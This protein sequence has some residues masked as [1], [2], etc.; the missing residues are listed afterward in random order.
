MEGEKMNTLTNTLPQHHREKMTAFFCVLIFVVFS[1]ADFN[2]NAAWAGQ[3]LEERTVSHDVTDFNPTMNSGQVNVTLNIETPT[4]ANETHLPATVIKTT[5]IP[6]NKETTAT[7]SLCG[8][9]ICDRDNGEKPATCPADCTDLCNDGICSAATEDCNNCPE[10]CGICRCGNGSCDPMVGETCTSCAQDC[11]GCCGNGTCEADLA[12]TC[13]NCSADCGACPVVC[14]DKQCQTGETCGSCPKDCGTCCGNGQ[15]SDTET[16]LNCPKDC[17]TCDKCLVA[18][19]LI[20]MADGSKKPVEEIKVG[21]IVLSFDDKTKEFKPDKVVKL[22]EHISDGYEIIND[23][24]KVTANHPVLSGGKWIPLGRLVKGDYLTNEKGEKEIILS[25]VHIP[26]EIKTYN[27]E[28][29]P[30]HAYI[31]DGYVLHNAIVSDTTTGVGGVC[32]PEIQNCDN[33]GKGGI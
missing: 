1:L 2:V 8:D 15:C 31:A 30:Y 16:C 32:D 21:D 17:G 18:G 24:L 10:D 11:G 13:S 27:F 12:E 22:F 26:G 14:G 19:A 5:I 3:T 9:D 6:R 7:W 20:T 28:V 29:N 4:S 23:R 33:L 25:K